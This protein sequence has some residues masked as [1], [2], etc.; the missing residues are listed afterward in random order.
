M[1]TPNASG[2]SPNQYFFFFVF[3]FTLLF[4]EFLNFQFEVALE[5]FLWAESIFFFFLNEI[6]F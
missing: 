1:F 6:V 5:S 2:S 3:N 4:G